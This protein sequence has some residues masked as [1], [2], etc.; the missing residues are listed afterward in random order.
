MNVLILEDNAELA[1]LWSRHIERRGAAVTCATG[2]ESAVA[3]LEGSRFDVLL[4]DIECAG[5]AALTVSDLAAYRD[6]KARVIFVTASRFF[7]DGLLF[8][9]CPNT[10]AYLHSGT[11]A[12]D[13]ADMVEH[14]TA[15]RA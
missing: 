4:L 9:I 1:L 11:P 15:V 10:C 6:P 5:G 2:L 7:S 3:A 8:S 12:K 14:Y 13:I